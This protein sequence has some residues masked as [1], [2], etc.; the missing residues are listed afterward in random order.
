MY[1][2]KF[3]YWAECSVMLFTSMLTYINRNFVQSRVAV[4]S[5]VCCS[6]I[7]DLL[8]VKSRLMMIPRFNATDIDFMLESV[9]FIGFF[10][11]FCVY[12]FLSFL[13]YVYYVRDA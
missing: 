10:L 5:D 8:R 12:F 13:F 3:S 2:N 6:V 4:Q 7:R 9:Y 1:F 11:C